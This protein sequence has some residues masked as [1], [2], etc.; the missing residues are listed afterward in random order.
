[1]L[2]LKASWP[3]RFSRSSDLSRRSFLATGAGGLVGLAV[4]S[5]AIASSVG[6]RSPD[7]FLAAQMRAGSIPGLA[8][9]VARGGRVLWARGY[10]MA[11]I[12]GQ[13]R[14]TKDSMFH[15]ASVTK[16]VTAAGIMMLIEE[17]RIALDAPV[18]RYLDFSVANPVKPEVA[19]TMRH[20]LMHMSSISDET[21]YHVDFRTPGRDASVALGDFLRNYL[22][23]GG[24]HYTPAGSFSRR[25]P[26][27]AYDYSNVAYGLL[28]YVGGRVAGM[29][30]R[31]YLGDHLFDRLGMR[32]MSWTLEG[33][34]ALLRVVPY[35]VVD[36]AP[37][38]IAPV[39]FPDWSAGMLRASISSFMPFVAASANRGVAG[40]TRMLDEAF[41]AQMLDMR[42]LPGLPS[43]LTGQGLGWMASADGGRP[44]INHWGGDPGVF[45]A[46]YLDPASTTGIAIFA[47][48]SATDASKA[49]IKAIARYLLDGARGA[50]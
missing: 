17:G 26:G 23:P 16:T 33:I 31:T 34:P 11:D 29:D 35:E 27:T 6:D 30:F 8:V 45:T 40:R 7:S 4:A 25:A 39:G 28:G 46:A 24:A 50:A 41:M 5:A 3:D 21:Y 48:V 15:I 14:I 13:R 9:G 1:M 18:N 19:I 37:V 20:L 36:R 44:H 38:P 47:N 22:V 12:A 32:H 10:G 2:K 49:A 43:W 42:V